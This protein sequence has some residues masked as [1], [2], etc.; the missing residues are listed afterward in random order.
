M[1]D[2]FMW[3]YLGLE[4]QE[5]L[6][7]LGFFLSWKGL[8]RGGVIRGIFSNDGGFLLFVFYVIVSIVTHIDFGLSHFQ[9]RTP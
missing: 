6:K 3:G 9:D 4:V 8:S 5:G 1:I 2:G 7:I